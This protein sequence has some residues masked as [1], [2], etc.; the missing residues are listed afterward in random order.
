MMIHITLSSNWV[1]VNHGFGECWNLEPESD[2]RGKVSSTGLGGI[3]VKTFKN[4]MTKNTIR[5]S[6]VYE[7]SLSE[8][9]Y[10][11]VYF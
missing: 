3:F 6:I 2:G 9:V 10:N 5:S 7:Y 4:L 8:G 1:Y 11:F